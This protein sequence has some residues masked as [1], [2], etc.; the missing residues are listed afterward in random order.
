MVSFIPGKTGIA[1]HWQAEWGGCNVE[2]VD[3]V[4]WEYK[5]YVCRV[6]RDIYI[7]TVR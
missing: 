3:S 6:I 4:S 2:S 5:P 7:V 1:L